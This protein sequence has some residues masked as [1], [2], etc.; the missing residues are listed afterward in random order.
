MIMHIQSHG[1]VR[2]VYSNVVK[3]ILEYSGILIE[4]Q[5]HFHALNLEGKG[6]P[7][8]FFLKIE[9]KCPDFGKKGPDYEV[10]L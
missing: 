2:T 6:R 7:L 3:D 4:I 10:P 8:L 9:K 1:I 5:S